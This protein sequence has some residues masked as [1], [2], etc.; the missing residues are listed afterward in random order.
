M[1]PVDERTQYLN[2][3]LPNVNNNLSH[4]CPRIARAIEGLDAACGGFEAALAGYQTNLIRLSER[5]LRLE[6]GGGT[7][8]ASGVMLPGGYEL[9]DGVKAAPLTIVSDGAEPPQSAAAVLR[10]KEMDF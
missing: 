1:P 3:P 7:G 10:R 9:A 8:E 2:L 6:L 4:D 5:I